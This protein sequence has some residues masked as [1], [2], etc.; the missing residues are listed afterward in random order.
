MATKTSFW[1][2]KQ[3]MAAL[4]LIGAASYFL[5]MEH[6]E[7]IIEFLPYIILLAC[8]LMHLMMHSGHGHHE[9]HDDSSQEA[10]KKGLEE[11]RRQRLQNRQDEID[12]D[13]FK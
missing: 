11:G 3:G 7:H 8:P 4:G 2:S 5:F 13:L 9:H 10:Y 6:R 12:E 1:S